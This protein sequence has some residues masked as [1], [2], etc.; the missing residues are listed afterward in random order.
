MDGQSRCTVSQMREMLT[1]L[2]T[3]FDMVR[4]VDPGEKTLLSLREDG[5][6]ERG[7]YTCFCSWN[8]EACCEDCTG[9]R[10]TLQD[11]RQ[12]KDDFIRKNTIYISSRPL[13]LALPEG[14]MPVVME[15]ISRTSDQTLLGEENSRLLA[16]CLAETRELLYQDELT[17]VFNRRYL[18][19]FAFL[20]RGGEHIPCRA[21]LILLDL[22]QFK[23]VNDTLGHLA[24]DQILRDVAAALEARVRK[25]DSV[26]RLG[27]DEFLV[28]LT[29][30]AETDVCR[31]MEEL[32]RAVDAISP[33]DFGYSYTEQFEPRV[34]VLERLVDLADR[35]MYAEKRRK[36]ETN[37]SR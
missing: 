23:R 28:I 2:R 19:E 5:T 17:K 24:G 3:V 36:S 32:R 26:I 9:T 29:D 31:V 6:L 30:C 7:P 22:N 10:D 11:C 21:G 25:T 20:R 33:A 13:T 16:D 15:I 1:C 18:N 4:L 35:R 8:K 34:H 27:G 37:L 14:D 12:I